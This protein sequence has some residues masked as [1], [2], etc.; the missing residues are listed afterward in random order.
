MDKESFQIAFWVVSIVLVCCSL[1]VTICG[2]HVTA[3]KA[4][5]LAKIKDIHDS[6]DTARASLVELEDSSYD[7]WME[8]DC[9]IQS[10]KI[11]TLHK[12]LVMNLTVLCELRELPI[13]S[14]SVMQLR[15]NATLDSESADRPLIH[16]HEKIRKISKAVTDIMNSELLKK[17]WS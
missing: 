8:N 12:R 10:Y 15:R 9:K 6:I 4:R 2:W 5:N 3:G 11:T 1:G 16:E 13:P 7:F 14:N 17:S